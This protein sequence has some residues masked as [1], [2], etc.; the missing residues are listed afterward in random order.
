MPQFPP[1]FFPPKSITHISSNEFGLE[2]V[3]WQ[4]IQ[5]LWQKLFRREGTSYCF[6]RQASGGWVNKKTGKKSTYSEQDR[7]DDIIWYSKT[8]KTDKTDFDFPLSTIY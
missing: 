6:Y 5:S 1:S 8:D 7:I 2:E 3:Q 4:D